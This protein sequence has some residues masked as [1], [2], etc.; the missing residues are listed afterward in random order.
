MRL[1]NVGDRYGLNMCLTHDAGEQLIEFYDR[2][3]AFHYDY[4]GTPEEA[5]AAGAP[6]LGQFVTRYRLSTILK[7]AE[8]RPSA[9]LMMNGGVPVW[10]I[11]YEAVVRG[12]RDLGVLAPHYSVSALA[13]QLHSSVLSNDLPTA[14]V[15]AE[16]LVTIL[17]SKITNTTHTN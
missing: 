9:T 11:E 5:K 17:R 4:V 13:L 12:L 7:S 10:H 6:C 1:V 16:N 8:K 14:L 2:T 15:C 3:H